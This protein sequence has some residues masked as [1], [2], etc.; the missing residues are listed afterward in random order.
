M[1]GLSCYLIITF[2]IQVTQW[3]GCELIVLFFSGLWFIALAGFYCYILYFSS[4][5]DPNI[6]GLKVRYMFF[7]KIYNIYEVLILSR[8]PLLNFEEMQ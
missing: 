6:E 5:S 7:N 2:S 3:F 1:Q 4:Y 8:C